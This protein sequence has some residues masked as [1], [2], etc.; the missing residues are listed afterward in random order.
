MEVADRVVGELTPPGLVATELGQAADAMPL[1]A[2][3]QRRSREM[4][5][6]RLE[7]VEAIIERQQRV[8]P[9]GD[10]HRLLLHG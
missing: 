3:M 4:R 1:K 9:K 8:A 10:D 2:A 5:D 7:T 6:A